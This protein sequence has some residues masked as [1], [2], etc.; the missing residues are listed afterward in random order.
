MGNLLSTT[1]PDGKVT[2]LG[3]DANNELVSISYSDGTTPKVTMTYDK[4]GQRVQ[5]IDGTGTSSWTWDALHRMTSSKD[6]AGVTV[7]YTY[8]LDGNQISIQYPA[9]TVTR[10][11]RR[12]RPADQR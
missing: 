3:Y 8:D 10:S 7:T 5:M 1:L 12:R 6:G 11:L 2:S 9:G 4:D